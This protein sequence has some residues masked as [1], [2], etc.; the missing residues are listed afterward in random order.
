[1]MSRGSQRD[2]FYLGWLIAPSY[3]SPNAGGGLW[4][5]SNKYSS[6]YKAQINFGD[7]THRVPTPPLPLGVAKAGINN[8]NEEITPLLPPAGTGERYSQTISN[9][10]HAALLRR[11]ELSLYTEVL[12]WLMGGPL[13]NSLLWDLTPYLT[14]SMTTAKNVHIPPSCFLKLVN[15]IAKMSDVCT[16]L[17]YKQSLIMLLRMNEHI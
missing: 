12:N 9:L 11:S 6:A 14:Y 8:L 2:I 1:M 10:G 3:M 17:V 7:L 13:V 4:G 15:T 5:L 16:A